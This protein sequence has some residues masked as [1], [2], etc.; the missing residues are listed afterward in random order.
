M[1]QCTDTHEA[2]SNATTATEDA[3]PAAPPLPEAV[4]V[5]IARQLPLQQRLRSFALVCRT[6]AAAAAAAPSDLQA[7][8][9]SCIRWE[10]VH[11]WLHQNSDQVASIRFSHHGNRR[12][13]LQL[14]CARLT[15]LQQLLVDSMTLR[16]LEIPSDEDSLIEED[17]C[18]AFSSC[19]AVSSHLTSGT[20][21]A[22]LLLPQLQR[23][24]LF[25]CSI[26]LEHLLQ[27]SRLAGLTSLNCYNSTVTQ[28]T[29][30]LAP[31]AE[32]A[33]TATMAAVLQ[34]QRSLSD[35]SIGLMGSLTPLALQ[36]IS[37]MQRLQRLQLYVSADAE[38]SDGFLASLPASLTALAIKD[39]A[40]VP[41]QTAVAAQLSRLTALRELKCEELDLAP[42]L[43]LNWTALTS[44][45]LDAVYLMP[46]AS[47]VMEVRPLATSCLITATTFCLERNNSFLFGCSMWACCTAAA[48][49]SRSLH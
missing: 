44:L 5:A 36:P 1:R 2:V 41:Q 25:S 31:A 39:I 48:S 11:K 21:A 49:A 45:V 46:L 9:G 4:L 13:L 37:S 42:A 19:C 27:L 20:P 23:L 10:H 40:L 3:P 8:L 43:L 30:S 18:S 22:P 15:R 26:A 47:H 12:Q 33:L 17:N 38:H 24:E 14:P 32:E 29:S 34:G 16:L 28:D 35:L 6:W 7:E